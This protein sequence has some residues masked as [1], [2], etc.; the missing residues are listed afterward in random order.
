MSEKTKI[1]WCDSTVNFW[2]GC[3][4]VSA[5]CAHCY[6]EAQDDRR[7]SRT[8]GGGTKE[9]PIRHWGKGKP[10]YKV[11]G[12]V[13][14]A[15][16]F[17]R[18]P[19]I[20]ADCGE[21]FTHWSNATTCS[22]S[23]GQH[24]VRRRRIFSLSLGDWLDDEVPIEWLAEMLDTIRQCDQVVWMLC[25]KRWENF[26]DRI[27]KATYAAPLGKAQR[28]L[29]DWK[30]GNPPANIIGL[31]SVESQ[32]MADKRI[33]QFLKVPL[34]CHGLSL[35]PLLGPVDLS[36][37]GYHG[38]DGSRWL[39]DYDRHQLDW[40]ILGGES[41]DEA[42]P[43][44][45]EWIRGLV[46]QGKAAGVATFVK[47]LGACYEDCVN[48]VAGALVKTDETIVGKLKHLRDKKGGDMAEWPE[49]MRV[50]EWPAGF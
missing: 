8:L 1:A 2:I 34:A 10:R 42:R 48:G 43:C 27:Y 20:C 38:A 17:N 45:V 23:I 21:A 18:K 44:N 33:P 6:A 28:W 4:K 39:G 16:A 19:W 5:G 46:A 41:G 11:Q 26:E 29:A 7:F 35:E 49:D 25:S 31:C 9:N 32:P 50:R 15:L 3:T 22:C 40:L 12:A 14:D 24:D 47:Q 30:L 36:D 13:A 37:Y